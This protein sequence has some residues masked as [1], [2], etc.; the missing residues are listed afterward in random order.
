MVAPDNN[1]SVDFSM[2]HVNGSGYGPSKTP[3]FLDLSN[4]STMAAAI[5]LNYRSTAVLRSFPRLQENIQSQQP[6]TR[7][8]AASQS[9]S[10][11]RLSVINV[12][13]Q[14][15]GARSRVMITMPRSAAAITS[16]VL[17]TRPSTPECPR[18][19]QT[20]NDLTSAIALTRASVSQL[21]NYRNKLERIN[22]ELQKHL[23]RY[24][25][26]LRNEDMLKTEI[27]RLR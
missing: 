17:S 11:L 19:P 3:V 16:A 13:G 27:K 10:G 20:V 4:I 24:R 7:R 2:V 9:R 1:G 23:K 21:I 14:Q 25:Q 6:L 8:L 22:Q 18:V 5:P 12:R 15:A 26:I